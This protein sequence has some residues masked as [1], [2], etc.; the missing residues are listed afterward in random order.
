MDMEEN[1]LSGALAALQGADPCVGLVIVAVLL[2]V[3]A[4]R[5]LGNRQ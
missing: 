5:A 1:A 4:L 2:A 3:V